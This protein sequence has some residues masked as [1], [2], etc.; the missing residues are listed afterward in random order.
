M[1]Q[2]V[3]VKITSISRERSR[4]EEAAK[5]AEAQNQLDNSPDSATVYVS[6]DTYRCRNDIKSCASAA[7][8]QAVWMGSIKAWR[9]TLGAWKRFKSLYPETAAGL[10]VSMDED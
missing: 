5:A 4:K 9:I 7:G 3:D 1:P 10:N 6:G 2:E 8:T